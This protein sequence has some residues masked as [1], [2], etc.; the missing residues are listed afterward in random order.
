MPSRARYLPTTH[1][2]HS[3]LPTIDCVPAGQ[4]THLTPSV[5]NLPSMHLPQALAWVG[6]S[7]SLP[8]WHLMQMAPVDEYL[9]PVHA[10]QL[11]A[12]PSRLGSPPAGHHAHD[13]PSPEYCPRA[14]SSQPERRLFGCLPGAASR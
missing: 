6:L 9:P 8:G 5:E 7:G 14:Q 4:D 13:L 12:P 1:A 10:L 2:A 3:A 11:S